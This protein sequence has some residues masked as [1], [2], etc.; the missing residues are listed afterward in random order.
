[1]RR[2]LG[3]LLLALAF[4]AAPAACTVDSDA[5]SASCES[6]L[7]GGDGDGLP[8]PSTGAGPGGDHPLN[9][10]GACA[11]V[12][13]A[14]DGASA[15]ERATAS[16]THRAAD[17]RVLGLW[18]STLRRDTPLSVVKGICEA[19]VARDGEMC[20]EC[21][22]ALM[23]ASQPWTCSIDKFDVPTGRHTHFG[24][25]FAAWNNDAAV[26]LAQQWCDAN[27]VKSVVGYDVDWCKEGFV[28]V[29]GFDPAA[30]WYCTGDV[31]C[32]T[33]DGKDPYYETGCT[34]GRLKVDAVSEGDAMDRATIVCAQ[35]VYEKN[36]GRGWF[37]GAKAGELQ[38]S[39]S[40]DPN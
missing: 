33:N 36:P 16:C 29:G 14:D 32:S 4:V 3:I 9:A 24:K 31:R 25:I 10:T 7:H 2:A 34:F 21:T 38:C 23:N 28:Q 40:G 22:W 39:Q 1:M 17:G 13:A 11:P 26:S 27:R 5:N 19:A 20:T 15:P 8:P 6:Q 30:S 12:A 35:S 18:S 37:C